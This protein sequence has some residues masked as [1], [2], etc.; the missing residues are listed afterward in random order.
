MK[1]FQVNL[2]LKLLD[3]KNKINKFDI[4][5]KSKFF[6][7]QSFIYFFV[8]FFLKTFFNISYLHLFIF[9]YLCFMIY[10]LNKLTSIRGCKGGRLN[11]R[12]PTANRYNR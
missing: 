5:K 7:S 3:L 8:I 4:T 10:F 2:L 12:P 1:I 11:N 6:F 9:L